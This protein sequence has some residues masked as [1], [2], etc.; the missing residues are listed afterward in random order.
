LKVWLNMSYFADAY[1]S[2]RFPIADEGKPGLRRAQIGGLH[3]IGAYFSL[4]RSEPALVV[5]PTGSG[6]TAV[7]CLAGFLLR[8]NRV[9]I[10]TPSQLVRAQIAE[11]VA[12]L[13]VLKRTNVLPANF[14]HPNVK[15]V[16]S[17]LGSNQAWRA[18]EQ[19]QFVVATPQCVSPGIK[20]VA[21]PPAGFFDLILMDEAHHSEAPRWADILKHFGDT[22]RLLFTATPFRRDKKEL[23]AQLIYSY[24]LR[25]A[26]QDGIFGNIRFLPVDPRDQPDH[27]VAIAI[28][29]EQVYRNDARDGFNHRLMVRT[30]SKKRADALAKIYAAHTKV[31][32]AVIHSGH[33]LRTIRAT[34]ARLKSG[35]IDGII[36]VAMMGEGFDFPELKIAAIHSP[37]KSLAVTLQ[38]IGRFA[39]TTGEKLGEAKF[40]A[41]PQ[42]I[43]AEIHELY[44]ESAAWQEI[45][46]DLS[47]ARIEREVRMKEVAGSFAPVQLDDTGAADVLLT[48]FKPF[49]HVKIYEL[50]GAPNL[51]TLPNFP[52]DITVL[53][54]EIS[55]EHNS[56]VLLVRQVTRPRWTELQRFSRVEYDLVIIYYDEQSRLLFINSSRRSLM[57]YRLFENHYGAGFAKLLSGPKINRVL[58]DLVDPDFFSVGLKNTVQNSNT[59]S[60]QI[61]AGPSAQNAISPTDGLLYQRGHL[62]GRGADSTGK[63]VTIGYSSSSKVWSNFSARVGELI[64]WCQMLAR[65]LQTKGIVVTGTPLDALDVGE[66]LNSLPKGV[67]GVGWPS[68][69]YKHFPRIKI[70]AGENS[71]EGQLL[72]CE[73]TLVR[74]DRT[75]REWDVKLQ[76]DSLAEPVTYRF[77]IQ[78]GRA[79][80]IAVDARTSISIVK[81]EEDLPLLDYLSHFP[82]SF[83]LEDFSLVDGTTLYRYRGGG[84][85]LRSDVLKSLKWKDNKVKIEVECTA[86]GLDVQ[87][88]KSVQ[89]FLG[90]TLLQEGNNIVFFDHG[91]GEIADFITFTS[92]DSGRIAINLYHC[93]A[94]GGETSGDRIEDAY[95]V[96]GQ[97]AKSLIWLKNKQVLRS[98]ILDRE[99]KRPGKSR[100]LKGSRADLLRELDDDKPIKLEFSIYVV[101]PGISVGAIS[102]KMGRVLAAAS[103]YVQ[104]ASGAQ[105]H[106]IGSP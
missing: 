55:D 32:L 51:T 41:V 3:A 63:Q 60:Y 52:G 101:Q 96:C 48:D 88:G 38:F 74:S 43:R 49:F 65:K 66:E 45:V 39:R 33:A 99:A 102:E 27:D 87:N 73:L 81:E 100:F 22:R 9:L 14:P 23:R 54:H 19:A 47:A 85:P 34:L 78:D 90:A 89:D 62:F 53:R 93:K 46:A 42:D 36:C 13:S 50:D 25:L 56:S 106:L 97:V 86:L 2:L 40:L 69:A 15:E 72:D 57:F 10:L 28:Q 16:K 35:E 67:I 20:G 44:R 5:M 91:S 103:H 79:T 80:T 70:D 59:E 76:H 82:F 71:A 105:M 58:A 95:E 24:P 21:A 8:V 6:K 92:A 37:H 1:A 75:D 12:S 29:A 61:K 11:E 4:P 17:R 104:R 83:Y 94:S 84:E 68:Q 30:D 7:I 64:E 77:R 18:L 31:N 98:K 26:H